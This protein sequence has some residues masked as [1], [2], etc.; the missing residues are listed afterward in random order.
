MNPFIIP[1]LSAALAVT[2]LLVVAWAKGFSRRRNAKPPLHMLAPLFIA[3]AGFLSAMRNRFTATPSDYALANFNSSEH[4]DGKITY[5]A[6]NDLSDAGQQGGRFLCVKQGTDATHIDKCGATDKPIGICPDAPLATNLGSVDLFGSAKGTKRGIAAVAIAVGDEIYTA[7]S[8]RLTNVPVDGC[9]LVGWALSTA[10]G[11]G[12]DFEFSAVGKPLLVVVIAA[13]NSV[14]EAT[15]NGS[16][17]GTTQAL[18]NSLK[19][20]YNTLQADWQA[21]H[22]KLV[23]KNAIV[24]YTA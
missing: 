5:T 7:A 9:Y 10:T 15:V 1:F 2:I 4:G 19:A 18:A 16:D 24:R 12:D 6:D 14:Q 22:D 21:F 8:G 17:A 13:S 11:A 23:G 20:K 3:C